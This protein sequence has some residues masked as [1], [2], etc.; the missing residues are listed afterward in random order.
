MEQQYQELFSLMENIGKGLERITELAKQKNAAALNDDVLALNE[1]I[2]HE[3]A[4]ALSFRGLERK[5]TEL[6]KEL[7]LEGVPLSKIPEKTPD[8]LRKQAEASVKKLHSRYQ[9]YRGCAETVRRTMENSMKDIDHILET[10]GKPKEEGPGYQEQP[11][12]PTARM[13][14]DFHA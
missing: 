5:Q 14:T 10:M 12:E 3:Q 6:L 2:N 11:V 9:V 13:R 1:I 7:G 8:L 4:E